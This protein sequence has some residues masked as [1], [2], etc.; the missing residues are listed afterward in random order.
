VE[1]TLELCA[2]CNHPRNEHNRFCHH[3]EIHED[4]SHHYCSKKCEGFVEQVGDFDRA[5]AHEIACIGA[6]DN[7]DRLEADDYPGAGQGD[8]D[9]EDDEA[10]CE[11]CEWQRS[12]LAETAADEL[13]DDRMDIATPRQIPGVTLNGGPVFENDFEG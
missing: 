3:E 12:F 9:N 4:G 8:Y 11:L 13:D 10:L 5:L 1:I 7:F 6:E 2:N